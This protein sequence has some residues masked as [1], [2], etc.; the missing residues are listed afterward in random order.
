MPEKIHNRIRIT[1][2]ATHFPPS[3]GF[4]GVCES[5]F[6]L[7]KALAEASVS[8]HVVTSDATKAGRIPFHNFAS[9]EQKNLKIHPFRFLFS[10]K[11]CISLQA[12]NKINMLIQQ[13][14]LVHA[15][16]IFTYPVTIGS[17]LAKLH[18]KPLIVSTRNGLDPWMFNI[19]RQKKF[20]GYTIYVR[21]I[22][23]QSNCIHV[24]SRLELEGCNRLGLKGPYTIIQ[25]GINSH[26]YSKLPDTR[27]AEKMF[28]QLKGKLVV[29][30]L[31]RLSPQKGLDMLIPVW[32]HI[33]KQFPQAILVIAGTDYD[34]YRDF[35]IDLIKRG[36]SPDTITIL[37]PVYGKNKMS[38]L[39]RSDIFVLPS[40][41]EN[42]GNAIAEAL[43]CATPVITTQATPWEN[44]N[45]WDCGRWVPV[46]GK[47]IQ[48]SIIEMLSK[49]EQERKA[50]GK[51][52]RELILSK[53]TWRIAASKLISVYKAMLSDNP[54][55]LHPRD[56]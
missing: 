14:D 47:A 34:E 17:W 32:G 52:G 42:F 37:G 7:S 16:G 4:G 43:G 21:R 28:P 27:L 20:L 3:K 2:V 5:S 51:R 29:L 30:F 18:R 24:T 40:Y 23:E 26:D 56:I 38:L 19:K 25:N 35:V 33:S 41:S 53:Y 31:S 50:M 12:I 9:F 49:S 1:F 45:K 8:V 39:A 6:G 54:I 48:N 15:N 11:S 22:L 46:N 10:E 55:P 44:I 13:S 36:G